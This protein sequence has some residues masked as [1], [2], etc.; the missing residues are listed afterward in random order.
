MSDVKYARPIILSDEEHDAVFRLIDE[1]I[2]RTRYSY[3]ISDSFNRARIETLKSA[4]DHLRFSPALPTG[5]GWLDNRTSYFLELSIAA[6]KVVKCTC[7]HTLG[8]HSTR[9]G[10][11]PNTGQCNMCLP[12]RAFEAANP[13]FTEE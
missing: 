4:L 8:E 12:C 10:T 3:S 5:A 1:E 2:N 13:P 9:S 11:L 7:G 6:R